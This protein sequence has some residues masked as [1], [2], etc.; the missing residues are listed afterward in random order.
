MNKIRKY[1][2]SNR[3]L[4]L[5]IILIAVFVITLFKVEW[6][7]GIFHTGGSNT[8]NSMF[9]SFLKPD[10]SSKIIFLA[11]KSCWQTFS[12][13][14]ISI[15]L[16]LI[17]A[18]PLGI[19]ASGVVHR[20]KFIV[21]ITRGI[22]GF[23]RA[24]HELIWAWIWVAAIGLNPIGAI[25]ALSIPYSGYLGKIFADT[26]A[27]AEKAPITNLKISGAG[28]FQTLMYGYFP[29]VFPNMFSYVMYRLEC[30]VRSSSVLSF[31]GLGGIGFQIQISLQDLKYDQVWTFMFF[32]I[33][34]ILIIDKWGYEVR[35]RI[36]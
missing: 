31:I 28:K 1:I 32:L 10:F 16:A 2:S 22:I 14:I 21:I 18:I 27:Q 29:A 25:F 26:L 5:T 33:I 24:V 12:Y 3:R 35:R 11:I 6:R 4:I 13:A 34:M 30:A 36:K 19:A 17:M 20:N 9:V 7:S 8:L 23:L 15:S